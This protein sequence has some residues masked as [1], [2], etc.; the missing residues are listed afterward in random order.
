[1]LGKGYMKKYLGSYSLGVFHG[2]GPGWGI[3]HV[4]TMAW[5]GAR[6]LLLQLILLI[7][8]E[9]L[10]SRMRRLFYTSMTPYTGLEET[11]SRRG[12]CFK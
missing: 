10:F 5:N 7:I 12:Q 3:L 9:N 11:L 6:K 1:M 4:E 8:P 2:W